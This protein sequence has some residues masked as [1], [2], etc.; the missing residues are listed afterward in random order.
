MLGR[1]AGGGDMEGPG[2]KA[3]N[4]DCAEKWGPW[5]GVLWIVKKV[6]PVRGGKECSQLR[7]AAGCVQRNG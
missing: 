5:E 1:G 7:A 4:V 6:G 2:D 3:K